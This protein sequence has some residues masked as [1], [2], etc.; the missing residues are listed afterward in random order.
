MRCDVI[1]KDTN[2]YSFL[3]ELYKIT[4]GNDYLLFSRKFTTYTIEYILIQW[5]KDKIYFANVIAHHEDFDI[6]S[7]K[8]TDVEAVIFIPGGEF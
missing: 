4:P 7:I 2:N 3:V 5:D 1:F 6:T 8:R